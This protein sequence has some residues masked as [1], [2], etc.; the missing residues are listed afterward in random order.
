MKK[1][2]F[3]VLSSLSMFS[4]CIASSTYAQDRFEKV[5]VLDH[6]RFSLNKRLVVDAEFTFLPLDAYYKPLLLDAALS[7]QFFDWFSWEIIRAGF[8]IYNHDTGLNSNFE[9]IV[10]DEVNTR[11]DKDK[12]IYKF[13]NE[14]GRQLEDFKYRIG[15]A[16]FLN[17]LYSK[18]NWF[19][20]AIVYH[21]WQAGIGGSYYDLGNISQQS[22]DFI[23]RVRFFINN[24]FVLNLRAAH[25]MGFNSD[26]PRNITSLG[27]GAGFAF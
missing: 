23:L 4:L 6:P 2:A 19:N 17:L 20:T 8:P 22:I 15:S 26:A 24:H 14:D 21:Y 13:K 10:K 27:L 18:S 12:Q 7:F 3:R 25:S 5:E 9:S 16:A 1:I 11:V